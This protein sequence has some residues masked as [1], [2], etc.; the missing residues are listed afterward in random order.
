ME[1]PR[2]NILETFLFESVCGVV[3][4][5]PSW[6]ANY[7]T[8]WNSQLWD[9]GKR[10]PSPFPFPSVKERRRV[11]PFAR[12]EDP[13]PSILYASLKSDPERSKTEEHHGEEAGVVFGL[14]ADDES[15]MPQ[16][17]AQWTCEASHC[18]GL[19][20]RSTFGFVRSTSSAFASYPKFQ[21]SRICIWSGL[22]AQPSIQ[23]GVRSANAPLPSSMHL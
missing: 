21:S 6:R 12:A 14:E 15:G 2:W 20:R 18:I 7:D 16:Q 9:G 19:V 17:K 23:H 8:F 11:L 4:W 22:R 10:G 13:R 3:S 5:T 1:L